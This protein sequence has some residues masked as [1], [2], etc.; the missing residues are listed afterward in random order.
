MAELWKNPSSLNSGPSSV[1]EYITLWG[2][3][4]FL[5][6]TLFGCLCDHGG[7]PGGGNDQVET[8]E[9]SWNSG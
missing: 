2:G 8:E 7:P 4:S 9:T 6:P 3:D 1:A 5:G